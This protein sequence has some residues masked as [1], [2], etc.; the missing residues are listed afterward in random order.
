MSHVF[1]DYED[2][3]ITIS[4]FLLSIQYVPRIIYVSTFGVGY[5]GIREEMLFPTVHGVLSRK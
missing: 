3:N 4:S 5:Q 2:L 1:Y